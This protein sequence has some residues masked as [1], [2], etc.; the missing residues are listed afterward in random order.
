MRSSANATPNASWRI[1][2]IVI[3]STITITP[4]SFA[5]VFAITAGLALFADGSF[6][7]SPHGRECIP[8]FMLLCA[9]LI[10]NGRTGDVGILAFDVVP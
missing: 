9:L 1:R 4:H 6:T 2:F 7:F 8:G 10:C 3:T 5:V